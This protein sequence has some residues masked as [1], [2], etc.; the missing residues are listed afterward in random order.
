MFRWQPNLINSFIQRQWVAVIALLVVATTGALFLSYG[1]YDRK[2]TLA[3]GERT[4]EQIADLTTLVATRAFESTRQLLLSMAFLHELSHTG[5]GLDTRVM[6]DSLLTLKQENPYVMDLLILA[7]DGTVLHWT[8]E[9]PAPDVRDREYYRYHVSHADSGLYIGKPLLSRVHQDQW[10]FA[11]SEAVRDPQGSLDRVLVAVIDIGRLRNDLVSRLAIPDSTQVLQSADGVIFLRNRDHE[12]YVGK[13]VSLKRD[14]ALLTRENPTTTSIEVSP[15]DHKMRIIALRRLERFPMIAA[16]SLSVEELLAGWHQRMLLLA[17]V[18]LAFSAAIVWISRRAIAL[19]R[20]QARLASIDS[21]TGIQNRG[22]IMRTA[23]QLKRSHEHAGSLALMMIDADH[24]K[25]I[26]DRYGHIAGDAVLRRLSE[27][28]R[29]QIRST[30]IVGRYGGEEFLVLMPDT[31]LDGALKLA[32]K[33]RLAVAESMTKPQPL[34]ISI[35]VATTSQHD[36][37]LDQALTRADNALYKAKAAGRNCVMAA[38]SAAVS[39]D[40]P[41]EPNSSQRA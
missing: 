8:G 33:L 24:F 27:I 23:T 16:G 32:E 25:E 34:T 31:G 1:L 3:E 39:H 2:A 19:N 10:F 41:H 38:Y 6:R 36:T 20:I 30:D 40:S 21:L 9:S 17:S 37:T 15:L 11:L 18:W 5:K 4:A 13:Q 28:L 12:L 26:N 14:F 7:G 29:T 22:A 35:G